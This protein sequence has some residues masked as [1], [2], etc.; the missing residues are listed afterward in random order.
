MVHRTLGESW[1]TSPYE[2]CKIDHIFQTSVLKP[3]ALRSARDIGFQ[4]T[5]WGA[6]DPYPLACSCFLRVQIG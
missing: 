1:P 5:G 3:G 4:L 6:A 2:D